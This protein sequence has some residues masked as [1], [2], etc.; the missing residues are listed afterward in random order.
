MFN[1]A[2]ETGR[3]SIGPKNNIFQYPLI[4]IRCQFP[5]R[6]KHEIYVLRPSGLFH[7]AFKITNV[8][9]DNS[10]ARRVVTICC[11]AQ[12]TFALELLFVPTTRTL[13][14]HTWSIPTLIFR[15]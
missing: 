7:F 1:P 15:I 13:I 9:R 6:G 3:L 14:F 8:W 5:G 11:G 4:N 12:L 10:P 2:C